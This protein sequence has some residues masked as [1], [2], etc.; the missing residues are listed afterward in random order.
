MRRITQSQIREL[1]AIRPPKDDAEDYRAMIAAIGDMLKGYEEF[2]QSV[3][4]G[5]PGEEAI[6][7]IDAADAR[8]RE[9]ADALGLEE[10][11]AQSA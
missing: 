8:A 9:R 1:R 5:R 2:Q 7:K 11:A 3:L 10:C 6:E 4:V